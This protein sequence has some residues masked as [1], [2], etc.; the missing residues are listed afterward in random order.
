MSTKYLDNEERC[1]RGDDHLSFADIE[2]EKERG[3]LCFI[4]YTCDEAP[5]KS[6]R[7]ERVYFG[8][9]FRGSVSCGGGVMEGGD[10]EL[11]IVQLQA[12]SREL[13]MLTL[14]QPFPFYTIPD[15]GMALFTFKAVSSHLSGPLREKSSQ[16]IQRLVSKVSVDHIKMTT[17]TSTETH[18]LCDRHF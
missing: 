17:S 9:Q 2:C 14:R 13:W 15:S 6:N 3:C 11:V 5:G 4:P 8:S 1:W 12:R 7:E 16:N 10:W 18:F